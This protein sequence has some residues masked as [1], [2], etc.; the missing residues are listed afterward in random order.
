MESKPSTSFHYGAVAKGPLQFL[1]IGSRK[2]GSLNRDTNKGML[3]VVQGLLSKDVE[4]LG[5]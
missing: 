4:K 2:R 3:L 5:K 1:G